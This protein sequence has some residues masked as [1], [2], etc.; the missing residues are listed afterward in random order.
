MTEVIQ[1]PFKSFVSGRHDSTQ[2]SIFMDVHIPSKASATKKAPIILWWHGG[3][4]L[5]GSRKGL[6][7]HLR[8][9][10]EKHGIAVVSADYRLAPQAR[11]P[12]ILSDISD[13]LHFLQSPEF[14]SS[15]GGKL[16]TSRIAVSGSSAGGWLALLAGTGHG[17]EA[18]GVKAPPLDS[19]CGIAAIYPITS[20]TDDF[21][22]KK[23]HP[24]S[25]APEGK[26]VRPDDLD[27]ALDPEG[28]VLAFSSPDTPRSKFYSYMV[29]EA[30]LPQLLLEGT[31]VK[32]E[33]IGIADGI[34]SGTIKS[35][36]PTYIV[37]GDIDDKVPL[38]QATD[39][40][41]A[42]AEAGLSDF[43]TLD[44]KK[45]KDHSYDQREGEDMDAMYEFLRRILS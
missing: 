26:M 5:Q 36:P 14:E 20:L 18:C 19:I 2:S 30:L 43:V 23:Q 11:M 24:V 16:D 4:L 33:S 34:R 45:G 22:L 31:Q 29:Q 8:A 7:P 10:P 9:A 40:A 25:F 15:T 41:E 28:P 42:A 44:I 35:L 27:G 21:W 39:V 17:F 1:V 3:G 6:A 32:A 38:R 37:H 12:S 13:A